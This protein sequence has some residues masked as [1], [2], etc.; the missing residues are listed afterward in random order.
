VRGGESGQAKLPCSFRRALLAFA[1][2]SL[3]LPTKP[4]LFSASLHSVLAK[5]A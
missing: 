2:A 1:I 4:T 5:Q 3:T